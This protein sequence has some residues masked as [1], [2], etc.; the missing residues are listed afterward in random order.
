[1]YSSSGV[2]ALVLQGELSVVEK[3]SS[4]TLLQE[5]S[6]SSATSSSSSATLPSPSPAPFKT[7]FQRLRTSPPIRPST[8]VTPVSS[9]V[10]AAR[11]TVLCSLTRSSSAVM[12]SFKSS[13][14]SLMAPWMRHDTA[15][16][17]SRCSIRC[18]RALMRSWSNSVAVTIGSL[19]FS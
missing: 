3:V 9:W 7:I 2:V 12:R 17:S 13:V 15:L 11:V 6:L 4:A 10:S 5:E 8:L 19:V 1:M 16:R 14:L 18:C